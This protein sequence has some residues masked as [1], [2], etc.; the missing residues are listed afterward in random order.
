M[1]HTTLRTCF[2]LITESSRIIYRQVNGIKNK[3]NN[4]LWL[5]WYNYIETHVVIDTRVWVPTLNGRPVNGKI[6]VPF[7]EANLRHLGNQATR[8]PN[9]AIMVWSQIFRG[10]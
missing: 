7:S 6:F 4:V 10:R 3:L 1:L 8:S 9:W 5:A 2:T